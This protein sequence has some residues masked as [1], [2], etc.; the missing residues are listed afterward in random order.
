MT[1]G[2]GSA[3]AVTPAHSPVL[4]SATSSA[5][6][7]TVPPLPSMTGSGLSVVPGPL[8]RSNPPDDESEVVTVEVVFPDVP[9]PVDA[10]DPDPVVPWPLPPLG[11]S[12]HASART[13]LNDEKAVKYRLLYR[14]SVLTIQSNSRS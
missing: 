14:I 12:E 7:G 9:D 2:I 11:S 5:D 13:M 1:G 8:V 3:A 6:K 10:V 4:I